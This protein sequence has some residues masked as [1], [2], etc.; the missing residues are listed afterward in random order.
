MAFHLS[1]VFLPGEPDR[2]VWASWSRELLWARTEPAGSAR[3]EPRAVLRSE[4]DPER[5]STRARS[6]PV[7]EE[8]EGFLLQGPE[9]LQKAGLQ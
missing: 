7:W 5:V 6:L 2:T 9:A 3:T 8:E 4:T 1:S